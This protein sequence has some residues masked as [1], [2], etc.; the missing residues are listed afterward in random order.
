MIRPCLLPAAVWILV[1]ATAAVATNP[2]DWSTDPDKGFAIA[3]QANLPVL[4]YVDDPSPDAEAGDAD[5]ERALANPSVQ[6]II[7]ERFVPI[8]LRQSIVTET[9]FQQMNVTDATMSCVVIATPNGAPI[10]TIPSDKVAAADSLEA[11]LVQMYR[12]Y[13]TSVL[14]VVIEPVLGSGSAK[15]AEIVDALDVINQLEIIEADQSVIKLLK[16][17][18]LDGSVR[19]RA[20]RTLVA[21]STAGSIDALL[22]ASS[23]DEAA[24]E[25]LHK[26][27]PVTAEA[28]VATMDR[29]KMDRLIVAYE[30]AAG[31]CGLAGVKSATFW[32]EV[33]EEQQLAEIER[34]KKVIETCVAAWWQEHGDVR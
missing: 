19:R 3:K 31:I 18:K 26:G 2:L 34:T 6:R 9:L 30:A 16:G 10:G 23:S 25:A 8:R 5:H 32:T 17:D 11:Q 13:R 22:N 14:E 33:G 21:L 27:T 7:K 24:A 1:T 15:P 29:K 20:Y 12:K 28:L 4:L